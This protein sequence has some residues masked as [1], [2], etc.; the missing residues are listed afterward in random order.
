MVTSSPL[1]LC[2]VIE[3]STPGGEDQFG[4]IAFRGQ[5]NA[6]WGLVPTAFRPTT[7]WVRSSQN[8]T[9][10]FSQIEEQCRAEYAVVTEFLQLADWVGLPVAGD[11]QVFRNYDRLKLVLHESFSTGQWPSEAVWETLA[12]AQHHGIATRF[13]DFSFSPLVAAFFAGKGIV[14]DY[15]GAAGDTDRLLAVWSVDLRYLRRSVDFAPQEE[16]I[17]VVTVPR[18][19]NQ[20][21]HAQDGLFLLDTKANEAWSRTGPKPIEKVIL[22]RAEYWSRRNG[23]WESE[24]QRQRFL[25]P[26][27]KVVAPAACAHDLLNLLFDEGLTQAHLTPTYDGVVEGLRLMRKTQTRA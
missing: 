1:N 8:S 12:I 18:A 10:P 15:T 26:M 3:V 23:F 21:L 24:E 13:L 2:R 16:P 5:A 20:F 4:D 25:P 22:D 14:T 9:G 11:S 6:D 17:R 7:K 19:H 27:T